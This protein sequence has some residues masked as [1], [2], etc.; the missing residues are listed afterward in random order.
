VPR[1]KKGAP[2]TYRRHFSGQARVTVRDRQGHRR[3]LLLGPWNSDESK[4]EYALS[5]ARWDPATAR[6]YDLDD[7]VVNLLGLRWGARTL[8]DDVRYREYLG[9]MA[10]LFRRAGRRWLTMHGVAAGYANFLARPAA[11]RL[12]C[13]GIRGLYEALRDSEASEWHERDLEES[14]MQALH[15]CWERQ[16]DA[17][18]SD[19]ELRGAFLGLLTMIASGGSH[20]ARALQEQVVRSG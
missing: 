15:A 3:D 1:T 16:R 4:T 2:P 10:D 6:T 7:M 14:L 9:R 5:H 11:D 18:V 20:A 17:V 19:Q 8:G 13:S 12:L